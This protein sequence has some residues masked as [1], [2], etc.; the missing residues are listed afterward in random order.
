MKIY[1]SLIVGKCVQQQ[2]TVV[3]PEPRVITCWAAEVFYHRLGPIL[4]FR[5][6]LGADWQRSCSL[7]SCAPRQRA[8]TLSEVN[9]WPVYHPVGADSHSAEP[10]ASL[11]TITELFPI[12]QRL[13]IRE[14]CSQLSGQEPHLA[15]FGQIQSLA[16]EHTPPPPFSLSHSVF[17]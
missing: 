8:L 7:V 14:G 16:Q 1:K 2:P 12:E 6:R 10:E 9:G 17:L 11:P 13:I 3:A 4:V 15:L 5:T